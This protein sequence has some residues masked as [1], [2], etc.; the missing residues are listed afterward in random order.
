MQ[1]ARTSQTAE[2][3]ALFRALESARPERERLFEDPL[4]TSFLPPGLRLAAK[5]ARLR[6]VNRLL[7]AYIDRRWPGVRTSAVARTRLIDEAAVAAFGSGVQQTVVLGAG[8]DSR[9]CRLAP[10]CGSAVF[11]VDHPSTSVTKQARV[12]RILG[13]APAHLQ[14]VAVN[15][16]LDGL[17]ERMES[18]GFG[19]QRKTLV[20]WEGVTNYLTAPA[21]DATL[22]WVAGLA[23]GSRLVFTY[24]HQ[25][26]LDTPE[27]FEG[28]SSVLAALQAAGER[29][30]FGMEPS[31]LR[32]YLAE[33][34][35]LLRSDLGAAE[36]R[37]LYF[38][39]AAAGMRGYEF[40]R[41]AV[42]DVL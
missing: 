19:P 29:W 8:F 7:C 6:L 31:M 21:V 4:A 39:A 40:Y 34:N 10:V 23:K 18:S 30:T 25:R 3:M 12:A 5:A 42:A 20:I 11:E 33:R 17:A 37:A 35:L 36:Y 41:V 27:S 1:E 32:E 28:T 14:F 9:A 13:A 22:R 16:D 2:Y 26:V 15:F 38:G 24:I